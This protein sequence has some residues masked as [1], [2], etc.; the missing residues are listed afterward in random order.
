MPTVASASKSISNPEQLGTGCLLYE[1]GDGKLRLEAPKECIDNIDRSDVG[2]R[3]AE[4]QKTVLKIRTG[5]EYF[6]RF[7]RQGIDDMAA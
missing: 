1:P 7:F 2:C 3:L 6:Y 5:N 4:W